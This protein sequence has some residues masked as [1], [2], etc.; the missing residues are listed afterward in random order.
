MFKS[1]RTETASEIGFRE[2]FSD[3]LGKL[4]VRL[5]IGGLMLFHGYSKFQNGIAGIFEMV[6]AAGLPSVMAYGVYVG[7]IVAPV[8]IILGL[9]TRLAAA[10]FAFNMMVAIALGHA[11]E[12]FSLGTYGEWAIET[13]MLFLLPAVALVL[14][15]PGRFALGRKTGLLA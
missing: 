15:G 12:L 6:D 10:V 3:S 7:E 14:M 8:L 5:T 2:P 4:L 9:W 11:S 13:P 1:K